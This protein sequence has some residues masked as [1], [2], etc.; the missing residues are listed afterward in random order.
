M[1]AVG[2]AVSIPTA[3]I[4]HDRARRG[5]A[6]GQAGGLRVLLGNRRSRVCAVFAMVFD[7]ANACLPPLGGE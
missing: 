1:F 3:D 4:D 6:S 5:V 2:A 7:F